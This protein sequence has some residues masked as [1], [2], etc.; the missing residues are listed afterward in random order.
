[1]QGETKLSEILPLSEACREGKLHQVK[2]LL[3]SNYSDDDDDDDALLLEAIRRGHLEIVK[4]L[5]AHKAI[6]VNIANNEGDT[7]IAVAR[8]NGHTE[9]VELLEQKLG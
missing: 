4:L 9:I 1:M 5:L 3:G 6:K 8:F 2:S 7:P